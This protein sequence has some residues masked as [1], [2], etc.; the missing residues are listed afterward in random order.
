MDANLFSGRRQG[1]IHKS[2]TPGITS[3]SVVKYHAGD[4]VF[5]IHYKN[6]FDVHGFHAEVLEHLWRKSINTMMMESEVS[7]LEIQVG[8][9]PDDDIQVARMKS[10]VL[11]LVAEI[12]AI[13]S[14]P[15]RYLEAV[16]SIIKA[17]IDYMNSISS[18]VPVVSLSDTKEYYPTDADLTIISMVYR[19]AMLASS[20]VRIDYHCTGEKPS[21]AQD[22]CTSCGESIKDCSALS[23]TLLLQVACPY[24]G[25]I[26]E[27][28]ST[29]QPSK[30]KGSGI[31]CSVTDE[32]TSFIK[33]MEYYEGMHEPQVQSIEVMFAELDTYF[34]NNNIPTRHGVD[35]IPLNEKGV[36]YGTSFQS[37]YTAFKSLRYNCYNE[38]YYV[39]NHY[40]L[41]TS[42]NISTHK[43]GLL[44]D[45]REYKERWATIP[46]EK[47][48][49]Q[50]VMPVMLL[51]CYFLM[52]R[53]HNCTYS[54]FK[55][56]KAF[57]ANLTVIDDM[58]KDKREWA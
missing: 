14:L 17:Y 18:C 19:Y 9:L 51:L 52:R 15:T 30:D 55:L 23:G 54:D 37:M 48:G 6:R 35:S 28:S 10:R 41:W 50:S 31:H 45:F 49:R 32:C 2:V 16:E 21:N 43:D 3:S 29:S 26:N 40:W 36:R 42:N 20:F 4:G 38:I 5:V 47:R 7:H 34:I 25:V 22:L 56:P 13:K 57:N 44:S 46:V 53:E 12:D 11:L 24:C 58:Y 8:C 39:C 1:P 33:A 27:R